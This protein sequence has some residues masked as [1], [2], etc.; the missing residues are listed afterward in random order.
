MAAE[1]W[2]TLNSRFATAIL[3]MAA[4]VTS[5]A[6]AQTATPA[7][8]QT[9]MQT[10]T[11]TSVQGGAQTGVQTGVQTSAQPP[12][13]VQTTTR[14]PLQTAPLRLQTLGSDTQADPFP[15]VDPK[16]FTADS[17]TAAMVDKYLHAVLGYD[18]ARIWRV[19]AIQKTAATGVSRVT[20]AISER[21]PQ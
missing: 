1:G 20:A 12:A 16:N 21:G 14:K 8:A 9:T 11:Q 7:G 19:E 2:T 6:W 10:G 18:P 3:A 4:G 15:P 5:S 17:P 13:A